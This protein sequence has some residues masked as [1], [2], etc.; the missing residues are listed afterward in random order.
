MEE[1][2]PNQDAWAGARGAFGTAI[3]VC[4]GLGSKPNSAVGSKMGCKAVMDALR[5][6]SRY[7]GAPPDLA[8]R[9]LHTMWGVRVH[10]RGTAG[11]RGNLPVRRRDRE[12]PVVGG[13]AGRWINFNPKRRRRHHTVERGIERFHQ[14]DDRPGDRS[15]SNGMED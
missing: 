15:R 5:Y 2:R 13:A 10:P 11:E 8:I 1:G 7:N 14:R 6:W 3:A 12:R 9:L 4:D